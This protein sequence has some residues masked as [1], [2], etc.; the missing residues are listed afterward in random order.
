MRIISVLFFKY[1]TFTK[2]CLNTQK[3]KP[4]RFCRKEKIG[5]DFFVT[6]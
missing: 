5:L 1:F 2:N 4:A 6:L 3:K